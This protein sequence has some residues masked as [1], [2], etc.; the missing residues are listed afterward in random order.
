M[1]G[2]KP[3][4][5]KKPKTGHKSSLAEQF[6]IYENSLPEL[7]NWMIDDVDVLEAVAMEMFALRG[8]LDTTLKDLA[9][10]K[11][12]LVESNR[13]FNR[14]CK[15]VRDI[16]LALHPS[17]HAVN[18]ACTGQKSVLASVEK[19]LALKKKEQ[20]ALLKSESTELKELCKQ[21][22]EDGKRQDCDEGRQRMTG[23]NNGNC[24]LK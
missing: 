16:K 24:C 7:V 2:K 11:S 21:V 18:P 8:E 19:E 23:L 1:Q 20:G 3:S 9:E 17:S 10:A 4:Q 14:E 5:K 22:A 6:G 12:N 15:C 13:I